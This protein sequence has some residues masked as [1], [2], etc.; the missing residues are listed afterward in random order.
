MGVEEKMKGLRYIHSTTRTNRPDGPEGM[1]RRARVAVA[2]LSVTVCL[3]HLGPGTL[4]AQG[5]EA[6]RAQGTQEPGHWIL[7]GLTRAAGMTVSSES[8]VALSRT[9]SPVDPFIPVNLPAGTEIRFTASGAGVSWEFTPPG[10]ATQTGQ[11]TGPAL[12]GAPAPLAPQPAPIIVIRALRSPSPNLVGLS[13]RGSLVIVPVGGSLLV[14][15]VVEIEEY[16]QSVVG[17]EIP[18]GWPLETTKAQAVAARSYAAY[19]VRLARMGPQ[20]NYAEDFQAV[21]PQD[22]LLWASDQVYRGVTEENP[23][24]VAA[25]KATRGQILTYSGSPIAAYFHSDAGGMTEDPR[26]VWGGAIPY[27]QAVREAPHDSPYSSWT[28]ILSQ[29]D[30][31]AGLKSIGIDPAPLPDIIAGYEPGMSGRWTGVAVRTTSGSKRTTATEFRRAFPQVRS[32]LFSSYAYG[33]GKETRAQLGAEAALCAQA[34]STVVSSVKL[35]SC[36]VM[37]DKGAVA[38][39]PRGA[40][41]VSSY[42]VE[43]PVTHIIQGKGWGHGVGLSQYGARAM[44]LSGSDATAILKLYY[45]GTLLEQWWQ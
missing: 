23:E 45:P 17:G 4:L 25:A 8:A 24:S 33:G 41:A 3:T 34:D 38:R 31:F 1:C 42:T 32:M 19:K 35:G 14:A 12:I 22:V 18:D 29:Q 39:N 11:S 15:N 5:S 28:V 21:I 37:G 2:V 13:F 6:Q 20:K 26:Y 9:G 44:A 16:V 27:L 30:L 10:G 40:F 7:V 43:S 36:V